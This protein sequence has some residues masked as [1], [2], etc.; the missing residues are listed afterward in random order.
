MAGP[1]AQAFAGLPRLVFGRQQAPRPGILILG[2][3][4]AREARI[5]LA[6]EL[7]CHTLVGLD[8]AHPMGRASATGEQI[9]GAALKAEPDLDRAGEA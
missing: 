9:D 8:V 7:H 5:S 6:A 1:G 3:D 2:L 4:Q